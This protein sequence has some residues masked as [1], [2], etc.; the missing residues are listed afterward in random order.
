MLSQVWSIFYVE[1]SFSWE[2]L[3]LGPLC[4]EAT[5]SYG[6]HGHFPGA[7]GAD[8]RGGDGAVDGGKKLGL[9]RAFQELLLGFTAKFNLLPRREGVCT[10]RFYGSMMLCPKVVVGGLFESKMRKQLGHVSLPF[11]SFF[12]YRWIYGNESYCAFFRP[13][14]SINLWKPESRDV[15]LSLCFG[16]K[17]SALFLFVL[18]C[19]FAQVHLAVVRD[20]NGRVGLRAC[21]QAIPAWVPWTLALL[22]CALHMAWIIIILKARNVFLVFFGDF[23]WFCEGF[24]GGGFYCFLEVLK[25]NV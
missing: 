19:F 3:L 12:G 6:G 22:A 10:C 14:N 5:A 17:R 9:T 4:G 23:H 1:V 2:L 25:Q 7:F 24:V 8:P 16:R 18:K 20:N 13:T 21:D 11:A 15:G